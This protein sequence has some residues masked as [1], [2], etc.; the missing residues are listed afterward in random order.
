MYDSLFENIEVLLNDIISLEESHKNSILE[1]RKRDDTKGQEIFDSIYWGD[2]E[3]GLNEYRPVQKSVHIKAEDD[4]IIRDL[5]NSFD[6]IQGRVDTIIRKIALLRR[7]DH[8]P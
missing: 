2:F 3:E 8:E 6:V 4:P 7:D 1:C 5:S